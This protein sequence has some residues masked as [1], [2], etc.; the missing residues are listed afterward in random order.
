VRNKG[1]EIEAN[2]KS[3]PTKDLRFSIGGN[4]SFARNKVLEL[5]EAKAK[6]AYQMQTGNPIGTR[7]IYIVE[8]YFT[9]LEDIANSPTQSIGGTVRPGDFKY[10]DINN[11]GVVNS[12][13]AIRS[14]YSNVPEIVYAINGGVSYKN[15]DLRVMF[16]GSAHAM[17]WTVADVFWEFYNG[18]KVTTTH[19]GRWTPETAETATYP[20]LTLVSDQDNNHQQNTYHYKSTDYLRLKNL[21]IGYSFSKNLIKYISV[22][23]LRIYFSGINLFT[24]DKMK[25]TDPEQ[26]QQSYGSDYPQQKL[27]TLGLSVTF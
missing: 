3:S 5:A 1:Y 6:Y 10:V 23:A 24:W 2:Y 20:R 15:A 21:E 11:D 22:D 18:A 14:K 8:R 13:D 25:I 9:S 12:Y 7:N 27:Y 16:Q 26:R 4:Y 17:V 19:L